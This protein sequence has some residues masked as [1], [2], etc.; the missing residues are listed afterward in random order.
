MPFDSPRDDRPERPENRLQ[1]AARMALELH[2]LC[3]KGCPL[4]ASSDVVSSFI[5]RL[6]ALVVDLADCLDIDAC[7]HTL[8]SY[9]SVMLFAAEEKKR[10]ASGEQ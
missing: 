3:K 6:S 8:Q 10:D 7:R 2:E 4:D 5:V 1:G 9:A